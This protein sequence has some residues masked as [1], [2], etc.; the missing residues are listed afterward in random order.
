MRISLESKFDKSLVHPAKPSTLW[1]LMMASQTKKLRDPSGKRLIVTDNFYTRHVLAKQKEILSDGEI[2]MIG[3]IKFNNIDGL[4][5]KLVK[6]AIDKVQDS[7]RGTWVL[8]QALDKVIKK[9]KEVT[10]ASK[11]AGYIIFK[12]RV[13]VTF[14]TNDLASTPTKQL[15]FKNKE[16][17]MCV[18][19]LAPMERW[20][21]NESMHRTVVQVPAIIVAYNIF[22]NGVDK[23]DQYR[24][25]NATERREKRVTMTI[26]TFLLDA[27]MMNAYAI[28]GLIDPRN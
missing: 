20:L 2:K 6:L 8:V 3:T 28:Q 4:N 10:V 24:S 18:R 21:G 12:D 5:R 7:E 19:G 22:M 17:V 25:T 11:N 15:Q 14:Y 9:K 16:S 27:A 13:V 26:F 23:F 1:C